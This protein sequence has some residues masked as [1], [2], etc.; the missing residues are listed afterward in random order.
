MQLKMEP[1]K[2]NKCI[3]QVT[4]NT[5]NPSKL[6]LLILEIRQNYVLRA[7]ALETNFNQLKIVSM[8]I[9]FKW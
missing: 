8:S 6:L 9:K 7:H 4:V 3:L 2:T 1:R 5:G